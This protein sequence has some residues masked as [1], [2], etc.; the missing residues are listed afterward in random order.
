MIKS[1]YIQENIEDKKN[2]LQYNYGYSSIF[3]YARSCSSLEHIKYEILH[4][5]KCHCLLFLA[6]QVYNKYIINKKEKFFYEA[7]SIIS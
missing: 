3:K 2:F 4:I 7:Y 1:K 5:R 6:F